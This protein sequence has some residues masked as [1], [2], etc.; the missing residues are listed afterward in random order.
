MHLYIPINTANGVIHVKQEVKVY[1]Q[2]LGIHVW[3]YILDGDVALL[4]LGLLCSEDG[5]WRYNWEPG[6]LPTLSKGKRVVTCPTSHNVPTL[7]NT[8]SSKASDDAGGDSRA[9]EPLSKEEK[10]TIRKITAIA[11]PDGVLCG[12]DEDDDEDEWE[13]VTNKKKTKKD[14]SS[15][16]SVPPVPEPHSTPRR[17]GK[18]RSLG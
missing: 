14:T 7:Y 12:S 13:E 1:V 6:Q 10:E 11:D 9:P 3:A 2:E 8:S 17:A 5:G 15:S 18:P 4:S 16:S